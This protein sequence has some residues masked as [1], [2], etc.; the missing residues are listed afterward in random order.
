MSS[1]AKL[2]DCT[3]CCCDDGQRVTIGTIE[4]H[5][6]YMAHIWG[7]TGTLEKYN[8]HYCLTYGGRDSRGW[9]FW[10]S[11]D[12]EASITLWLDYDG[13]FSIYG[14]DPVAFFGISDAGIYGWEGCSV[15]YQ[16]LTWHAMAKCSV[17]C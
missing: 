3:C 4:F 12:D 16:E 7:Q 1:A 13:L 17:M 9:W 11:L 15:Y 2:I 10:K 6:R 5:R 14:N 8:R